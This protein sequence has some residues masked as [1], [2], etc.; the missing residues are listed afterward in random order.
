VSDR[1]PNI[2]HRHL[3]AGLFFAAGFLDFMATRLDSNAP[4]SLN[5]TAADCR[6]AAKLIRSTLET[7]HLL[8]GQASSY[9]DLLEDAAK[10]MPNELDAGLLRGLADKLRELKR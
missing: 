9:A 1:Q 2:L 8:H 3:A 6:E 7:F 4:I 10:Y 5:K